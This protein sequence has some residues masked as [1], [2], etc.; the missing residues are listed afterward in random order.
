VVEES[1]GC[2][3]KDTQH[4]YESYR[5]TLLSSRLSLTARGSIA[6]RRVIAALESAT[7]RGTAPFDDRPDT[8]LDALASTDVVRKLMAAMTATEAYAG[9]WQTT[10]SRFEMARYRTM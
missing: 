1:S 10:I 5:P 6:E 9:D 2:S 8:Y 7:S 4:E 3:E